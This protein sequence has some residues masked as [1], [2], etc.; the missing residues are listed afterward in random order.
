MFNPGLARPSGAQL[1]TAGRRCRMRTLL[2]VMVVISTGCQR[3]DDEGSVDVDL[4]PDARYR[5]SIEFE[6]LQLRVPLAAGRYFRDCGIVESLEANQVKLFREVGL[7]P[8]RVKVRYTNAASSGRTFELRFRNG[9]RVAFVAARRQD[10]A[11]TSKAA[12]EHE[13][14]HA[15]SKLDEPALSR[16]HERVRDLGH[17]VPWTELD[18]ELRATVVEV[19]ALKQQG[20]RLSAI[21]GSELI[22]RAR[23]MLIAG[24]T[25]QSAQEKRP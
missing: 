5:R 21:S 14:Y 2:A 10:D 3:T 4:H 16:V 7:D 13:R 11:R 23:D 19:V 18:E 25:E 12:L 1:M 6:L 20:I 24:S 17:D 15:L 22:V 9:P 8:A